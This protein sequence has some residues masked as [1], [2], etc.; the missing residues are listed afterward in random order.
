MPATS[1]ERNL[2]FGLLAL[3]N[4]LIDQVQLIAAFQ[5]WTRDKG[6]KA[7]GR[8]DASGPSVEKPLSPSSASGSVDTLPG[9]AM[10]TPAYM[11]P[12]QAAGDLEGL[13]PPSDVYSLGATLY[14]LL[15]GRVPFEG[16]DIGQVLGAVRRGEFSPP[17]AVDRSIDR[18]LEAICLK[19]MATRPADRYG[20]PRALAEDIERLDG[21]RAGHGPIRN[22]GRADVALGAAASRVGRAAVAALVLVTIVSLLAA[23]A[24]DAAR[25]AERAAHDRAT[26]A[27]AAET[28]ALE[29]ERSAKAE[30][31]TNF[32]TARQAVQDYLT[33][34]SENVL[35]KQQDRA[36][37]R[38]AEAVTGRS[39]GLLP[40]VHLTAGQRLA[41]A[42][43]IG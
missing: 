10:G 27:L 15:T 38:L 23:L 32:H 1:A 5:S 28:S 8:A 29:A 3:Q 21:G 18:S 26:R 2:L 33:T 37:L 42:G 34:V 7:T 30:A 31:E 19:A 12:E 4:G 16:S 11:S 35:L 13:G 9:S 43:G 36:D 22:A 20:S 41:A 39:A 17:K 25:G 14:C 6:L 24:I 40:G